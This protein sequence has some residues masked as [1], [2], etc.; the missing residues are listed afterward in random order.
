MRN[1]KWAGSG[2]SLR[3]ASSWGYRGT[4]T[5][6]RRP[7]P[8]IPG[9]PPT[10]PTSRGAPDRRQLGLPEGPLQQAMD[11]FVV[12]GGT[13]LNGTLEVSGAKNAVLPI[14]AAGLLTTEELVLPNAPRLADVQTMLAVL[15]ELGLEASQADS[16]EV[17]LHGV[18]RPI[19][20]AGW[21]NVRRMRGSICVL[22]PLLARLGRAQVSMPGGCVFGVRPI[23]VHLK[24]MQALGASIEVE[25][26]YIVATA[27]P[28]GLRGAEMFLG[29]A[30]GPSV[31]GTM[32][33]MMA[34]TLAKGT[35]VIQGAACEPEVEDL[36]HCLVAM[37][38][39]I[40]GIGSPRL[41]I[42]GVDSLGGASH[43]VMSDR[44]EAGTYLVAGAITGG[45][46]RV[47][48]CKP[49][50]LSALIDRLREAG[51]GVERGEDWIEVCE[52]GFGTRPRPTDVT[53]Q[54]FPGFPT[55]LQAQWMALMSRADGVSLVT[56]RIYPDRYMH[57]PEL[58]RLGARVRRQEATAVV[59]GTARLSGAHVTASDL[60]ASAALVLA[61][62]VAEG[63]TNVHRV[64][65]I[66]RGYQRIEQRLA[67]LGADIE[68]VSGD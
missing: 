65:H 60:R 19:E 62:L 64:Y 50:H 33:V 6:A 68:R 37:G 10:P 1:D 26:G 42:D 22:G 57:L 25:H 11:R 41:E 54:P 39:K 21:D 58:V 53:T 61:G 35:T 15:A 55:D 63:E 14:M 8:D 67:A 4:F 24:G 12:R 40:D 18:E 48:R 47:E 30:F 56:E 17:R 27:P 20:R 5:G 46:V 59:E 34:A 13:Q 7:A 9:G 51:F 45:R 38:A 16:G 32:N 3:Q 44:I 31:T 36:A 23:D 43:Q 28:G 49:G 66:D 29:T 2:A 52:S